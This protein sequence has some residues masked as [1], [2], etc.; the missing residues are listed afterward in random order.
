[1]QRERTN[2][3]S[4]LNR[5]MTLIFTI[6]SFWSDRLCNMQLRDSPSVK[7]SFPFPTMWEWR[8]SL[9]ILFNYTSHPFSPDH[10]SMTQEL[11]WFSWFNWFFFTRKRIKLKYYFLVTFDTWKG[12]LLIVTFDLCVYEELIIQWKMHSFKCDI[13]QSIGHFDF[14]Y[15]SDFV[16]TGKLLCLA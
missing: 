1:M 10:P 3:S 8:A 13:G 4:I 14:S 6:W 7:I 12:F 11:H 9:S 15:R 16:S 2:F 5:I